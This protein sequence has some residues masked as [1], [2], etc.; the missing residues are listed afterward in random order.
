VVQIN[1]SEMKWKELC[2]RY[3][4]LTESDS[5]WRYN[6]YTN[7]KLPSQGWKIHIS[8]NLNNAVDI[9]KTIGPLLSELDVS[10][11]GVKS[12]IELKKINCGLF[13]GYSQVGKCFTIYPKNIPQLLLITDKLEKET[14]RFT[15]PKVPYDLQNNNSSIIHFRYGAFTSLSLGNSNEDKVPAIRNPQGILVPDNRE[16]SAVPEWIKIPKNLSVKENSFISKVLATQYIPYKVLSQRGKGGVYLAL[17]LSNIPPSLCI[18]KEGRKNG[19]TD[20]DGKDGYWRINHEAEVLNNLNSL[21]VLVPKVKDTFI[22]QES[23]YVALEYIEGE[24]LQSV[25]E[26]PISLEQALYLSLEVARLVH[27][28]HV[29]GWIWRD[30]K[31]P[32]MILTRSGI[33]PVDFEGA[34]KITQPEKS[35]WG[36]TGYIPPEFYNNRGRYEANIAQDLYALGATLHQI[37][38]G[39]TPSTNKLKPIG[40]LRYNVP[41]IIRNIINSLLSI[42]P[43]KRP[44]AKYVVDV[45]EEVKGTEM[46]H[47][48]LG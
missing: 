20:W 19:E 21:G 4:P 5:I 23:F 17:N 1:D 8:A 14:A 24:N 42:E 41:P 38:S 43:N 36:T 32:N 27:Q 7:N 2:D 46:Q 9:F 35:Q 3:L 13:Y 6:D 37:Y 30:C 10:F 44:S 11:K 16:G 45:L 28:L 33:I 29:S 39:Q 22:I 40:R 26:K 47:F 25:V 31:P 18:L 12:L 48:Y 34:C 15:G